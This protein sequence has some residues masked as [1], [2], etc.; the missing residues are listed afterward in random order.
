MEHVASGALP[1]VAGPP[2]GWQGLEVSLIG[3]HCVGWRVLHHL[4]QVQLSSPDLIDVPTC[5]CFLGSWE[6]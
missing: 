6:G 3:E 5:W 2:G 4:L 1:V